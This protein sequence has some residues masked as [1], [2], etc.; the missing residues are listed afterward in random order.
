VH[1][2]G[3]NEACTQVLLV[4]DVIQ[5]ASQISKQHDGLVSRQLDRDFFIEPG[6]DQSSGNSMEDSLLTVHAASGV[7]EA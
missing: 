6:G 4:C 1:F 7:Q 2:G 5:F 3:M